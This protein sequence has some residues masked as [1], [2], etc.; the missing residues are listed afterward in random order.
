M[1]SSSGLGLVVH[2]L[3]APVF[4]SPVF[5]D[6][7]KSVSQ[8]NELEETKD[9]LKCSLD[10]ASLLEKI[11]EEKCGPTASSNTWTEGWGTT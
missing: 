1:S 9:P 11:N 10:T 2:T 5:S 3:V 6:I 7:L 8:Q 4:L